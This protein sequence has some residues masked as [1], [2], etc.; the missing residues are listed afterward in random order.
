MQMQ[1]FLGKR[2]TGSHETIKKHIERANKIATAIHKRFSK[3][4]YQF[5]V[6]HLRW[7]LNHY[8]NCY[9]Q[10]TKY[11][12]WLTIK[13]IINFIGKSSEWLV[14]LRGDWVKP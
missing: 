1:N 3:N 13:L 10:G 5:Q 9:V 14:L 2:L 11:N 8:I 7:F 12:Y 6:K 4:V